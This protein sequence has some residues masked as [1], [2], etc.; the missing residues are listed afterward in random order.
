LGMQ[1]VFEH[2]LPHTVGYIGLAERCLRYF[3]P[4][5]VIIARQRRAFENAFVSVA[6][7]EEVPTAMLIHGHVSSQPV[8]HFIDG[9][10]DQME[11]IFAWGAAQKT[12]LVAKGASPEQVVVTGNP[13]WDRM[14]NG[15]DR[16]PGRDACRAEMAAAL[17]L[18]SDKFWVTFTSQTNSRPFLSY[19]LAAVRALPGTV[20][21]V[22]VHPVEGVQDYPI[23]AAD[24]MRCRVVKTVDLHILLRASD[25]VLTYTSTTNLEALAVGTPLCVVDFVPNP[26]IPHRI[27][28]TAYGIPKAQNSEQLQKLLS[29]L[30]KDSDWRSD[31]LDG[32]RRALEDYAYSLDGK[33]TQRV[34][35]ALLMLAREAVH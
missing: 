21:I 20:L 5:A 27:D 35:R 13:Q 4:W 23:P 2:L 6:R 1:M 8:Y 22:K 18:P 33:A 15:L 3:K 30:K 12:T 28:L 26:D 34:M 31:L 14:A 7:R 17:D 16:L 19:I 32:G 9:R 11:S 29:R 25:V 24:Q 10:F